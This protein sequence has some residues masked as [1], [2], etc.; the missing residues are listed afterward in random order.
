MPILGYERW[1]NFEKVIGRAA[2]S[3][4]NNNANPSHHIAETTK[5]VGVGSDTKRR[6]KDYF[7]DRLACYLIAMNGDPAKPE[8]AAAQ[9]YFVVRTRLHE[10]AGEASE[11]EKRLKLRRLKAELPNKLA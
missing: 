7:L 11:D 3:L 2:A 10:L 4:S 8:I 6:V 5:M 9:A 1:E